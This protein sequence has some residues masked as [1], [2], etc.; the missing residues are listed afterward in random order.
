M[1]AYEYLHAAPVFFTSLSRTSLVSA[2]KG[3]CIAHVQI[4]PPRLL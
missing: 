2:Q 1:A 3:L 4:A